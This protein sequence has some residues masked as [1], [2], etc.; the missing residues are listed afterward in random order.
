MPFFSETGYSEKTTEIVTGDGRL[1][2]ID[3]S[4]TQPFLAEVQAC[5]ERKKNP[6][7]RKS[8]ET[9]ETTDLDVLTTLQE[10]REMEPGRVHEISPED[11]GEIVK[12]HWVE[13]GWGRPK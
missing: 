1:C 9:L 6:G 3:L 10:A 12:S 4:M 2:H 8:A 13:L 7:R 11:R 5:G